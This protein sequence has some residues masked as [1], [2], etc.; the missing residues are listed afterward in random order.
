MIFLSPSTEEEVSTIIK[1]LKSKKSY[2]TDN[3]SNVVLKNCRTHLLKPLC[4]IVNLSLSSGLFPNIFKVTKAKPLFKKGTRDDMG[5][6]RPI[7][8]LS[9]FF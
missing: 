5:N 4:H 2:G 3:V 1:N 6:Y 8:L 9:V 7:A